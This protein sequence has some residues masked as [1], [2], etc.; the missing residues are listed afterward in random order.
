MSSLLLTKQIVRVSIEGSHGQEV[1]L[2]VLS[3]NDFFGEMAILRCV[4][5]RED[6]GM[7][8]EVIFSRHAMTSRGVWLNG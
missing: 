5:R 7:A 3:P 4:P 8:S 6:A 2:G 1:I